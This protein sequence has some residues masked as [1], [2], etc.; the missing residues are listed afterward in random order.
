MSETKE[1]EFLLDSLKMCLM[2]AGKALLAGLGFSASALL[3]RSGIAPD[4]VTPPGLSFP[5]PLDIAGIISLFVGVGAGWVVF[6]S[7]R[8]AARI[9]KRLEFD[10]Q[11]QR[12]LIAAALS[13]SFIV[14]STTLRTTACWLAATAIFFA[15]LG[16]YPFW[17]SVVLGLL[18]SGPYWVL[19]IDLTLYE[20]LAVSPP[21]TT[22]W[23]L[24]W[25]EP[26]LSEKEMQGYMEARARRI[27]ERGF[28]AWWRET[29]DIESCLHKTE[30]I[31]RRIQER[32]L[33]ATSDEI[34][35]LIS[36][37]Q[38]LIDTG[39][40]PTKMRK[41]IEGFC[42]EL[43]GYLRQHRKQIGQGARRNE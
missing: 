8:Q 10:L 16:P 41:R 26:D 14:R 43:E 3:L 27:R 21:W 22:H 1:S 31:L 7:L 34:E 36:Y 2:D 17:F 9:M 33:S 13:C 39:L 18:F 40:L 5:V 15:S 19:N 20:F 23:L 37:Q 42:R 32:G 28:L 11:I 30:S 4:H 25:R 38:K 24:R 35:D 29:R 12:S 6:S